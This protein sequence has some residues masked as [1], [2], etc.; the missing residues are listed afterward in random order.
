MIFLTKKKRIHRI[1]EFNEQ[2]ILREGGG[3]TDE[4]REH[5]LR[6]H[7]AGRRVEMRGT[8]SRGLLEFSADEWQGAEVIEQK[9]LGRPGYGPRVHKRF[10]AGN[11]NLTWKEDTPS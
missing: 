2:N 10:N 8:S 1:Q 3:L 4:F 6:E 7:D 11:G 9:S 5:V